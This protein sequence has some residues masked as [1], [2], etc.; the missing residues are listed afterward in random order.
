MSD[1]GRVIRD[2][3]DELLRDAMR[4]GER[5]ILDDAIRDIE[6]FF[7]GAVG[8]VCNLSS[9]PMYIAAPRCSD[10]DAA[11]ASNSDM[12]LTSLR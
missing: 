1:I 3:A 4:R 6:R 8:A 10:L 7:N 5:F 2:I 9:A 11:T 12:A